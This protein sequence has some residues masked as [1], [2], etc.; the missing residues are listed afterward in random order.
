MCLVGRYTLLNQSIILFN[1]YRR[2]IAVTYSTFFNKFFF[3]NVFLYICGYE[4]SRS[5][6]GGIAQWPSPNDITKRGT[7]GLKIITYVINIYNYFCGQSK[8]SA[9]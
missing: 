4:N 8:K 1:L 3:Q 9:F 7:I 6:V 5:R 2:F